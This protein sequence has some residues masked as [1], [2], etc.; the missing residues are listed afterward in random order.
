MNSQGFVGVDCAK[1]CLFLLDLYYNEQQGHCRTSIGRT[2]HADATRA[3]F[4]CY[5][6]KGRVT[7]FALMC[8]VITRER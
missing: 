1:S 4:I 7:F 5:F 6:F 8:R 3:L 2:A